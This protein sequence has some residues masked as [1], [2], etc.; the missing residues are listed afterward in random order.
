MLDQY[1]EEALR[2]IDIARKEAKNRGNDYIGTEHILLALIKDT[3]GLPVKILNKM[4]IMID[5][6]LKEIERKSP[7]HQDVLKFERLP[8]SPSAKVVLDL[9]VEEAHSLDNNY[10]AVKDLLL[11][12]IREEKGLASELLRSFGANVRDGRQLIARRCHERMEGQ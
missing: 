6:V 10:V 12:L 2:L 3:N 7:P 1:S 4:G 5:E 9:A 11:G 8:F